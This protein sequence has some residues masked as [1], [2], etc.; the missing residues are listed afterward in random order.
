MRVFAEMRLDDSSSD[1]AAKEVF[2][3]VCEAFPANRKKA[4]EWHK[5]YSWQMSGYL[6]T[7]EVANALA[8]LDRLGA[9]PTGSH[10]THPVRFSLRLDR[11]YEAAELDAVAWLTFSPEECVHAFNPSNPMQIEAKSLKRR[12]QLAGIAAYLGTVVSSSFRDLIIAEGLSGCE[13]LPVSVVDAKG[14]PSSKVAIEIVEL[15][16]TIELPDLC[17]P[18]CLLTDTAGRPFEGTTEKG[19]LL[20][21]G[22]YWEPELYFD[23]RYLSSFVGCDCLVTKEK[24]GID[25]S[26]RRPVVVF[27]S[28]FRRFL[29]EN[30]VAG[31]WYPVHWQ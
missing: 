28:R 15:H 10:P 12:M 23:K 1:L 20:S 4:Q 5:H 8:L 25:P 31:R 7:E 3:R 30:K 27:S 19:P 11:Q 29:I 24:F 22:C 13:F 18:P 26:V 6:D 16:S 9:K 2:D 17:C 14:R 21:G